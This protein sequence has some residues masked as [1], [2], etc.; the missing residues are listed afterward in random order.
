VDL[1]PDELAQPIAIGGWRPSGTA[2]NAI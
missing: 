1:I 2:R